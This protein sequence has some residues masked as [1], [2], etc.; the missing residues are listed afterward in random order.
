[1]MDIIL[2]TLMD[3]LKLLPFLFFA[4]LLMEYLEHKVSDKSKEKLK[5][6]GKFGPI[7]GSVLGAVPQCGFSAAATNL[8]STNII[9]IGTLIAIYL[10]TSDEML[11]ILLSEQA[12]IKLIIGTIVLKV[13]IGLLVGLTIDILFKAKR[14]KEIKDFC[15]EEHCDCEHGILKSTIKHTLNILIF[16]IIVEFILNICVGY[17]GEET[18]EKIF[19]KDNIFSYFLTSLIGLIPNCGASV[20]IT[21]LYLNGAITYGAMVSGLL[22]GSGVALLIL[23]KENKNLKEN[24]QILFTIY[25]VGA[26]SG[27][28]I[29]LISILL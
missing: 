6:S 17:L 29:D 8:Y 5:K 10:S 23:F 7:F 24:F 16:I 21:E 18:L 26:V 2:D 4:F 1:M 28:I 13:I 25:L 9:T 20:A 12:D 22:T 11:P 27:V 19:F 14:N 3:A 15:T